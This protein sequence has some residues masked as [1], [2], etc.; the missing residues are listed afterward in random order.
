MKTKFVK[1]GIIAAI[2]ALMICL[3]GCSSPSDEYI[4]IDG[5]R[6]GINELSEKINENEL[7]VRDDLVNKEITV[8][9]KLRSVESAG[10]TPIETSGDSTFSVSCPNGY[11][12]L[13]ESPTLYYVQ[14]TDETRELA[15]SLTKGEMIKASGIF[16]GFFDRGDI[17]DVK[18]LSFKNSSPD[19]SVL[20]TIELVEN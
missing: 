20:P 15:S 7:A 8:I 18:L 9:A 6:M 19:A 2:A 16:S 13:G 5:E 1:I 17:V 14:I 4:E 12:I 10:S 11:L 3:T